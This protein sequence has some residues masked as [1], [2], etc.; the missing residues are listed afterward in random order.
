MDSLSPPVALWPTACLMVNNTAKIHLPHLIFPFSSHWLFTLISQTPSLWPFTDPVVCLLRFLCYVE[1]SPG[2]PTKMS[3]SAIQRLTTWL[4]LKCLKVQRC[5][6]KHR[7]RISV[8]WS[9]LVRFVITPQA[10]QS[11]CT[12]RSLCMSSLPLIRPTMASST[13]TCSYGWGRQPSPTSRSSMGF[14]TEP[15]SPSLKD[16]QSGIT[17]LRFPTV[18]FCCGQRWLC[19]ETLVSVS[20]WCMSHCF[21]NYFRTSHCFCD[22]WYFAPWPLLFQTSLCSTSEAER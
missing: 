20:Y 3:S 9:F 5:S 2:T 15:T 12:G 21:K 19:V 11:P 13:M 8:R 22:N 1:A 4:W 7:I 10:R 18:S 14:Y 16:F 6:V 17:A